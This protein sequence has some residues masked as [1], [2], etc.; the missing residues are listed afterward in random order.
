MSAPVTLMRD[1]PGLI[2]AGQLA[3]VLDLHP[4]TVSRWRKKLEPARWTRGRYLRAKLIEMGILNK[5]QEG[6]P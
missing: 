6:R 3:K 5:N 1:C 2:T 4:T